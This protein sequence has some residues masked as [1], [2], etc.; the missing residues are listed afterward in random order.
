MSIIKTRSGI[1]FGTK[2]NAL[3]I[4][5]GA[6]AYLN[7]KGGSLTSLQ[8]PED[9]A[10]GDIAS[11][12]SNNLL[13]YEMIADVENTGVLSG[14]IEM[15]ARIAIGNGPKVCKVVNID[16]NGN[17]EL[18]FVN[19]QMLED[20]ME[21]SNFHVDSYSLAKDL[22]STGNPFDQLVLN[23]DRNFIAAFQRIDP[24]ECR[25]SKMKNG[26]S[27]FI[28]TSSDWAKYHNTSNVAEDIHMGKIPLLN[29]NFPHID[30]MSRTKG[31][32]FA[33]SYQYPLFGRKYYAQPLW[34]PA[35]EWVKMAQG[36]PE[37]KKS[38]VRNQMNIN[39]IVEIHPLFWENY[40]PLFKS[41]DEKKRIEIMEEFYDAVEESLVGGENAYKSLFSTTIPGLNGGES[42]PG[43]KIT[44][45]EDK[46]KEGKLL[47][48]SAAANSEILFSLLMNPA[49]IGADTPGGP[50][51]GG[52]GS[53]SNIRETFLTQVIIMEIERKLISR[54]FT[55]AKHF[56]KWDPAYTLRFPN[57]ILTTLNSGANTAPIA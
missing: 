1:A 17:E 6:D 26:H 43:I 14:A 29:K 9:L 15:K 45:I 36:I 37:L 50:Y 22:L 53:G 39:Y 49:I 52:A 24:S 10:K 44:S 13:P 21:L 30:L 8:A 12:G 48:D 3:F 25:F 31:L 28:Y 33:M 27:E 47:V 38:M 20:W 55:V 46:L 2:S 51:S 40:N 41:A 23:K 7:N 42:S 32:N 11:W 34:W 56:N 16:A 18:E 35:R 19:D 54:R 57:K 5:P 4:T